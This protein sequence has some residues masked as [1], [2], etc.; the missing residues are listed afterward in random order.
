MLSISCVGLEV[1]YPRLLIRF[2]S[3]QLLCRVRLFAT[4]WIVA[5]Q[6]SLSITNSR[7]SLGLCLGQMQMIIFCSFSWL[8]NIQL[9]TWTNLYLLICWWNLGCF[10]VLAIVICATVSI[11]VHV[12]FQIIKILFWAGFLGFTSQW[13]MFMTQRWLR[14]TAAEN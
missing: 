13:E 9:Y 10:H 5:R 1:S 8:S 11:G 14:A 2:S 6:A 4:P 3:V 12:S 7:S